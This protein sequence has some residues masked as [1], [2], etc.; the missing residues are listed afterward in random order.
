M[1]QY[2]SEQIY[3]DSALNGLTRRA[4]LKLK[5]I[6]IEA[7]QDALLSYA[8]TA[9]SKGSNEYQLNDGQT[10]IKMVYRTP[11]QISKAYEAFE[12]IKNEIVNQLNGRMVRLSDGRNFTGRGNFNGW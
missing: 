8:L 6:R 11:E 2:D 3:V 7:I 9:A 10:I 5:V 4:Q 1:V 12:K